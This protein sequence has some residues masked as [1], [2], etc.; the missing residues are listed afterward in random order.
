MILCSNPKAQYLANKK[1]ID[2]AIQQVLAKG[3]FILGENVKA[4][5]NEFSAFIGALYTISVASGTDAICLALRALGINSGDEII[6]HSHTAAATV[7]AVVLALSLI[8]I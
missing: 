6:V 4:F 8:H 5:E 7:A 1:E 3:N 2:L